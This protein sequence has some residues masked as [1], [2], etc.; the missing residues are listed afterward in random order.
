M[1]EASKISMDCTGSSRCVSGNL[2]DGMMSRLLVGIL[3]SRQAMVRSSTGRSE[4]CC[5]S[6]WPLQ[7]NSPHSQ[8]RRHHDG[9]QPTPP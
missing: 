6:L 7:L 2:G 9:L 3:V 8:H 4:A 5:S 1:S